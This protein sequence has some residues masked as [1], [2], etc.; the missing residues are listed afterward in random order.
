MKARSK[1]NTN[2]EQ[3]KMAYEQ[4]VFNNKS[5]AW[6]DQMEKT[7]VGNGTVFG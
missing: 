2:R 6:K 1:L 4:R 3:V 7:H 5:T